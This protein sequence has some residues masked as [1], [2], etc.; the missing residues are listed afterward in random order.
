MKISKTE[1]RLRE[2]ILKEQDRLAKEQGF[3]TYEQF[4]K[5]QIER[6][7]KTGSRL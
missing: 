6:Q 5:A 7:K 2:E 4:L 3:D 1:A